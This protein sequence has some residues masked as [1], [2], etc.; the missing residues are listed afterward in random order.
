MSSQT[1]I[2][3]HFSVSPT[4]I[5]LFH[6]QGFHSGKQWVIGFSIAG[7]GQADDYFLAACEPAPALAGIEQVIRADIAVGREH[8]I[9]HMLLSSRAAV[10]LFLEGVLTPEHFASAKEDGPTLTITMQVLGK[11]RDVLILGEFDAA[12]DG[13]PISTRDQFGTIV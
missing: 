1:L 5:T 9:D 8:L 10:R 11:E 7:T 6:L 13:V 4:A 3:R 2:G 12:L